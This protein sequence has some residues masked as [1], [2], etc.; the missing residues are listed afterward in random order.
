MIKFIIS[1]CFV[2]TSSNSVFNTNCDTR[3]KCAIS[4]KCIDPSNI[5]D[6]ISDCPN[7]E[8]EPKDCRVCIGDNFG[9]LG[10]PFEFFSYNISTKSITYKNLENDL[11]LSPTKTGYI[12]QASTFELECIVS[13]KTISGGIKIE[14]CIYWTD[15]DAFPKIENQIFVD[16]GCHGCHYHCYYSGICLDATHI[17]DGISDCASN[18]DESQCNFCIETKDTQYSYINGRYSFYAYDTTYN[19]SVYYDG[20]SKLYLYPKVLYTV[21]VNK[22]TM[23]YYVNNQYPT[24]VDPI[25]SIPDC[26][27]GATDKPLPYATL[28][29]SHCIWLTPTTP[30]HLLNVTA[31]YC[32]NSTTTNTNCDTGFK[33]TI[34][35]EC[36]HL[37]NV[38]DGKSDC[39][40]NEDEP[41]DCRVCI[42][43]THGNL[44]GAFEFLSYNT[45]THSITYK[46]SNNELFLYPNKSGYIVYASSNNEIIL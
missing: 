45:S 26:A 2:V 35:G 33:C 25:T 44:G 21:F 30:G 16:I 32:F 28:D 13:N 1:I 3:F 11:L 4:G 24:Q 9:R 27:F 41:E 34:S 20:V 31:Q 12:I 5:C 22:Y 46:N 38:C 6:G 7:N 39:S 36:I 42:G 18:K 29:P 40:H 17:C 15:N 10:G 43:D 8:D 23:W 19:G 14:N 37:S